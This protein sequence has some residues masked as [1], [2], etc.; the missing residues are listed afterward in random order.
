MTRNGV[1]RRLDRSVA[2]VLLAALL[3]ACGGGDEAADEPAMEG[4]AETMAAAETMTVADA[5][6][7]TPESVLHDPAAD[8]YIVSNISGNPPEKD[9][10]GFL[11]RVSPEGQVIA[12]KWVEGGQNGVT[13]HAPKGMAIKGDT[14]FV[15]DIDMVRM[16]HRETGAPLGERGVPGATFLNDVAVGPDGTVYVSDS[17]LRAGAQGFGPS[18]TDAIYRFGP[19][20]APQAVAQ[21]SQLQNPN[22]LAVDQQGIIAVPFGGNA[23]MRIDAAGNITTMDALPAGGLDGVVLL[24]DGTLLVSSWEGQAVYHVMPEM[25]HTMVAVESV[26]SPADIGFDRQRM[27]VLIPIFSGDRLEIRSGM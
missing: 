24:D 4:A 13:L 2:P 10:D 3:A 16:F 9:N 6:F 8:V 17:G 11:S 25:G 27:R 22:G 12:L 14:L 1:N 19:D 21:G 18:G 26:E 23:P 20:G 15:A 7:Q 5:G